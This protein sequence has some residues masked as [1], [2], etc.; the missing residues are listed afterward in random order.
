MKETTQKQM[1]LDAAHEKFRRHGMRRITMS[2]I[3]S[4]L[5]ISKKTLYQHFPSKE[6][7][8][9]E[10][11]LKIA[12]TLIPPIEAVLDSD[13]PVLDKVLASWKVFSE[14]PRLISSEMI[15][16]L[17]AEYPHL[18]KEI[19]ERRSRVIR[20]FEKVFEDGIRMGQ[21]RPGIHPNVAIRMLLASV[22]QIMNPYVLS[23]GDFS[24]AEAVSTIAT[25]L[26]NGI[27]K[28]MPQSRNEAKP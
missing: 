8:V 5:R 6:D 3:A 28:N 4:D 23:E 26:W 9:R 2:E 15:A 12:K 1:I 18:W 13:R 17:K 27:F 20:K 25:I 10:C 11:T 24:P 16:D 7:L 22:D 19:E 14:L 21:V